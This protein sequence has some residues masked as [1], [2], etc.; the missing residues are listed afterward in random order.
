MSIW[1]RHMIFSS[2][3][4]ADS[5]QVLRRR[6]VAVG[7]RVKNYKN[8]T[9]NLALAWWHIPIIPALASERLESQELSLSRPAILVKS[10]GVWAQ[11]L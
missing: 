2:C 11:L 10:N 5:L 7:F 3:A 8:K 4:P 9:E 1:Q 6:D